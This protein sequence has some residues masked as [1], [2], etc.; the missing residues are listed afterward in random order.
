MRNEEQVLKQ[1]LDFARYDD[2]IRAVVLNGSR[3]NP[4][5]Q[6]DIFCDYDVIYFVRDLEQYVLDTSWISSF[7]ELVIMQFNRDIESEDSFVYLMQ[8]AD[9]VRIDLSFEKMK[10]I[11]SSLEDSLTIVL[12]DKDQCI[13]PIPDPNESSYITKKPDQNEYDLMVNEFWWVSTYVAKSLWR[14]EPVTAKYLFEVIMRDC[15]NRMVAWYIAMQ[16][17][18]QVNA[19]KMGKKFGKLLPADLWQ[20]L[21]STYPGIGE[22]EIWQALINSG[23]LMRKMSIPV[24]EN[25][26]YTYHYQED[27]LVKVYLQQVMNLPKDAQSFD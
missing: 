21:L 10:M 1:I 20:E 7:G 6:H 5:I 14:G 25:L 9:G 4:N 16:H 27:E 26:G 23:K 19:G 24:A 22:D 15:V 2:N 8:F 12:L 3:V 11:L 18:W 17:D 13:P